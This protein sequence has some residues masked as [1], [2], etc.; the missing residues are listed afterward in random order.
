MNRSPRPVSG[1]ARARGS[2]GPLL[3]GIPVAPLI[4]MLAL[5]LIALATVSLANG[6]LP[7]LPGGNGGPGPDGSGNQGGVT[8]TATPPDVVVV[9]TSKPGI[10]VPGSL[11]YAKDGNVWIQADG[12]ATQLTTGGKDSTPSFSPDGA[13]VYF[14]RTRRLDG[15]W[16]VGG[17]NKSY[18]MDVPSLMQVSSTGGD[19][20]QVLDGLVDPAGSLKWMGFIREPILAPDGRTFAMATDLPDPTRSDVVIKSY[21][22]KT[23]KISDL[24]LSQVA[25]LGHQSPAWRPDG[26]RLA[27]V[28]NDRDGA[29]GV[30]RIYE[31]NVETGKSAAITG[32]GYLFPSWSPDGKYLAVTR[33]TAF[34]TDVT[35]VNGRTGAELLRLTND[36]ESWAPAWSPR[37]DQIAYLHVS[38]QVVDLRMAQLEGG[39]PTWSVKETIELTTSAGLDGVSRPDWFIP[40]DQL[41]APTPE[42][43]AVP[44]ASPAAS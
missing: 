38:G 33:T 25:P 20:A 22:L 13:S 35:I 42:P 21:D 40:A 43:T 10:E 39:A 12:K 44:A 24:G 11:L 2:R 34:G 8:G 26:L 9:P 37:G 17:V 18:R 16:P 30:P 41:P 7:F 6:R 23:K 36:G 31:Y 29:K 19:A 28:R 32:P 1:P 5:A 14:V 15:L 4:S 27:Y 3:S